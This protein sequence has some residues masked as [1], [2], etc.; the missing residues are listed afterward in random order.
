MFL[1]RVNNASGHIES[2]AM[3]S[4]CSVFSCGRCCTVSMTV[5]QASSNK[6]LSH[7]TLISQVRQ[8]TGHQGLSPCAIN[9]LAHDAL[10][11]TRGAKLLQSHIARQGCYHQAK[12]HTTEL[13]FEH[14]C[15]VLCH[16]THPPLSVVY[17]CAP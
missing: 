1:P 5:V 4:R 12:P 9:Q 17:W 14:T 15:L 8:S 16:M 11:H 13:Y 6:I 3:G 7:S 2:S 10:E